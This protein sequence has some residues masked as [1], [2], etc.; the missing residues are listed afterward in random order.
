MKKIVALLMVSVMTLS[1]CSCWGADP[2]TD[3]PTG[4]GVED[5]SKDA[6][7]EIEKEDVEK[8][9]VLEEEEEK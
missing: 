9:P 4:S 7:E 3:L 1:L 8:E 2:G 6:K 5:V